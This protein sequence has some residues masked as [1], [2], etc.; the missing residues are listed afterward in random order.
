MIG[1][2]DED[3]TNGDVDSGS[4]VPEYMGGL[5]QQQDHHCG[6]LSRQNA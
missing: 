2:E 3:V 4:G 5:Q 1:Y 6:I